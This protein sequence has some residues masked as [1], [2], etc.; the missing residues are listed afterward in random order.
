[1]YAPD[2]ANLE[3]GYQSSPSTLN[4][5]ATGFEGG[6]LRNRQT[7][8]DKACN[9]PSKQKKCEL[10]PT[11]FVWQCALLYVYEHTSCICCSKHATPK[12]GATLCH[13]SATNG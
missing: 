12:G 10:A 8:A 1:M 4:S 7:S 11:G 3:E 13:H 6:Q 5:G 9:R 2:Y